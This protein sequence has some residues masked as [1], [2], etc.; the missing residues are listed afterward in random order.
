MGELRETVSELLDLAQKKVQ[1]VLREDAARKEISRSVGALLRDAGA[2]VAFVSQETG[3]IDL[4]TAPDLTVAFLDIDSAA[5]FLRGPR[6]IP[7]CSAISILDGTAPHFSD[8]LACGII[9]HSSGRTWMAERRR[10]LSFAMGIARTSGAGELSDESFAVS[11]F[12]MPHALNFGSPALH[13]AGVSS[14]I[15]D[16]FAGRSVPAAAL[17]A[18]YLAVREAG[19]AVVE[20]ETGTDIGPIAFHFDERYQAVA[21]ATAGIAG[22]AC[23]FF[24][25]KKEEEE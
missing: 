13:L 24:R 8:C 21:G 25:A 20:P 4:S 2:R 9:E 6:V 14:G 7:A 15:F 16:V 5:G 3:R 11:D 12:P 18:G 1:D 10:G 19:G 17:S 22:G 23:R